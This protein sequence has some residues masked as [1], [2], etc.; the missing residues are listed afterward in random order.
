MTIGIIFLAF[1]VTAILNAL[2][3]RHPSQILWFCYIGLT[4]LGI[5]VLIKNETMVAA[6]I[7]ILAIPTL[8]W[9]TDFYYQLFTNKPL[10]G[11]TSY[12]FEPR[13]ALDTIV[14]SSHLFVI[15]VAL[16]ALSLLPHRKGYALLFSAIQVLIVAILAKIVSNVEVNANCIFEPCFTTPFPISAYVL[17]WLLAYGIMITLT[18][19]LLVKFK[20]VK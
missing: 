11:I 14:T 1:G 18:H 10:L 17:W 2:I 16:F 7:N 4:L 3:T 20:F 15:P 6:Q 5:G 9:V 19:F 12:V 8:F 13:A